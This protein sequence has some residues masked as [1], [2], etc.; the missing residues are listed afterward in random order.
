ML[1]NG[2]S[3]RHLAVVHFEVKMSC[4]STTF[5]RTV[6]PSSVL[7]VQLDEGKGRCSCSNICLSGMVPELPL[8]GPT[9]VIVSAEEDVWGHA[10]KSKA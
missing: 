2:Y 5:K 10:T 6:R 7:V 1:A 3:M 8:L 9:Q 4:F